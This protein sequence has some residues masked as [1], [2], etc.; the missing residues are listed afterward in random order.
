MSIKRLNWAKD[1]LDRAKKSNSD[2]KPQMV[3]TRI[4]VARQII[5]ELIERAEKYADRDKAVKDG[6]HPCPLC[7]ARK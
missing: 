1:L 6:R 7:G 4:G 2:L 5:C 3:A